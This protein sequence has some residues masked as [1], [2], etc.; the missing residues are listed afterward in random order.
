MSSRTLAFAPPPS[1]DPTSDGP[2]PSYSLLSLTPAL[3]ALLEKAKPD[4]PPFEIRGHASDAAVLVTPTETFSLRGVQNSNSLCLCQTTTE[5]KADWYRQGQ[6]GDGEGGKDGGMV[7][8]GVLH[9]TLE[10][11]PAAAKTE[12]LEGLL[13]GADYT[14]E[15]N[16][17]N[18]P[19]DKASTH[20]YAR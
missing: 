17:K 9:E 19:R 5:G 11:L 15:E 16:E 2:Q 1:S 20:H 12:R 4:A 18:P 13:R 14:G 8:E 7:I 3:L 6:L 10:V